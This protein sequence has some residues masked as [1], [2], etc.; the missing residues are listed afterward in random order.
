MSNRHICHRPKKCICERIHAKRRALERYG[1]SLTTANLEEICQQICRKN[2]LFISRQS[3]R[4]SIW[5]VIYKD[6]TMYVV[7]DQF[8]QSIVTVLLPEMVEGVS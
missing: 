4:V 6:T 3:Q 8:R 1:L 2:A 5:K 7:Y